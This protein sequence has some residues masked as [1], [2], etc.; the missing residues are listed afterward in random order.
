MPLVGTGCEKGRTLEFLLAIPFA[1]AT[2]LAVFR[3]GAWTVFRVGP[4]AYD[5]GIPFFAHAVQ[6][7]VMLVVAFIDRRVSYTKEALLRTLAASAIVGAFA[8]VLVMFPS[9]AIAYMGSALHGAAS[10]LVMA[11]LGLVFCSFPPARSAIGLA[12][13][14]AMYG[15][16]TWVLAFVP[17]SVNAA[18][19]VACFPVVFVCLFIVLGKEG[20]IFGRDESGSVRQRGFPWGIFAVLFICTVASMVARVVVPDAAGS[21]LSFYGICWPLIMIAICVFYGIWVIMLRKDQ[22]DGFWVVFVLII[23]SG[24]LCWLSF[25]DVAPDFAASF[26]RATR[27]CLMLFCWV[28]VAEVAYANRLPRVPFFGISTLLLLSVPVVLLSAVEWLVPEWR[29]ALPRIETVFATTAISFALVVAALVL[30]AKRPRQR[31]F[32][33]SRVEMVDADEATVETLG[34]RF[35]LTNREKEVVTLLA[36]GHTLPSIAES[37]CI[38]L[39]TVRSHTKS[40]YRKLGVHKKQALIALM[41]EIREEH[42]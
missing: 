1:V 5:G 32:V 42:R 2:A 9:A 7:I 26:F 37:L 30:V 27:E 4:G 12:A 38:S 6:A 22:V 41:D 8:S 14:F 23:F 40:I 19:S 25:S 3:I 34:E 20:E 28:V 36:K 15:V 13:A 11:A 33:E 39:D 24:L 17:P 31:V 16:W 18:S 10:A 35:E 29:L 21:M